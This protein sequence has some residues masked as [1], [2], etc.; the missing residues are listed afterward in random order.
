MLF[1]ASQP[2]APHYSTHLLGLQ[3]SF[4]V[5]RGRE[6]NMISFFRCILN[7]YMRFCLSVRSC[8]REKKRDRKR[9]SQSKREA[10]VRKRRME[11]KRTRPD[12]RHNMR[13]VRVFPYAKG[14]T[15]GPTDP[16]T[17]PRTD[18]HTLL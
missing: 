12:T 9:E 15:D 16:Q 8:V 10:E 18:G 2:L 14:L 6:K 11:R 17:D 7:L 4:P 3:R 5:W 1:L 13:L